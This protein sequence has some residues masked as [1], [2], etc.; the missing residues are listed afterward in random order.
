MAVNQLLCSGLPP[1]RTAVWLFLEETAAC[2][3]LGVLVSL[4]AP[5]TAVCLPPKESCQFLDIFL[6]AEVI[7]V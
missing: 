3:P 1:L 6:S 7:S 2:L 4:H 5:E